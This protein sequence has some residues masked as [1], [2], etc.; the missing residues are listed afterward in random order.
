MLGAT[1]KKICLDFKSESMRP[2]KDNELAKYIRTIAPSFIQ[3][4]LGED[5]NGLKVQ[6]SPGK[7]NWAGVPWIACFYPVVTDTATQGYYVVYLFN[8]DSKTVSLSL[9]QGTTA[10]IDEF[11]TSEGL[12]VLEE[13]ASFISSRLHD[14]ARKFDLSPISLGSSGVLARG[15]EAGHAFGVTY[16][17][18]NMP[19][20]TKLTH[21]LQQICRA[22][23]ALQFRGGLSPSIEVGT[24]INETDERSPITV[25]EVKR[26][27]THKQI[28]RNPNAARVAKKGKPSICVA[29]SFDF[30]KVYGILGRGYVEAHHLRPLATLQEGQ[31]VVYSSDDFALLCANCHRMIHRLDDPSDIEE[32]QR[33]IIQGPFAV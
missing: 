5:F 32:L 11:G 22:Y 6:G 26:Y 33:I 24:N 19:G 10:V 9:N 1:L 7:G 23:L 12:K 2:F 28:E 20:D 29:C 18:E 3:E 15:Y 14:F 4:S 16:S 27:R 25:E 17:I 30:E 21:D 31:A 13:R 8:P